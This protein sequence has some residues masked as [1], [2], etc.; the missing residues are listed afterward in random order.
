MV[1]VEG[2]D[3]DSL[4]EVPLPGHPGQEKVSPGEVTWRMN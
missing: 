2:G 1:L 4:L 3:L